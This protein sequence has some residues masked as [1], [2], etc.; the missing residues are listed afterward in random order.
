MA[1]YAKLDDDEL[2]GL[3]FT[4]EDRLP[5]SAVEEFVR[6]KEK[7]S[8]PLAD[9]VS[10]Q[11]SWTRE[12][13]EWWAVVH[14][15][16]IIGAIGEGWGFLPLVRALRWAVA[17]DCDWV[18]TEL[19]SIFGRLG[20]KGSGFLKFIS[21]DIT[22]DWYTRAIA[23]EGLAAITINSPE[24]EE[25]IFSFIGSIFKDEHEDWDV[26][27]SA[28]NIL[29]D[30]LRVDYKDDLLAF[31]RE[32]KRL[33]DKDPLF[34]AA[35]FDSDVEKDFLK[36]EKDIQ[37]YVKDWLSFYDE[38]EIKKR[39]ERWKKEDEEER[40]QEAAEGASLRPKIGRNDPCPCGSGKK[41]KKC[42]MGKETLH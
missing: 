39:Q 9:I 37:S 6:R 11:Y 10:S 25:E 23:M 22:S 40:R 7:V 32:E 4:E 2:I 19:P 27:Q 35:F 34:S 18:A 13:P 15:V 3:L 31:G 12:A 21:R 16:Y 28:G 17:Y 41:Y 29:M 24:T 26:K 33:K 1:D 36:G 38:K 20:S 30:F 42:C 5:R 14:A 8:W